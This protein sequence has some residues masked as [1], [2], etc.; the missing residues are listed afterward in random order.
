MPD[1]RKEIQQGNGFQSEFSKGLL[2]LTTES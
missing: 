2:L 1:G